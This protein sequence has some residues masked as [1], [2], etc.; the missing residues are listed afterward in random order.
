MLVLNRES[1]VLCLCDKRSMV[2]NRDLNVRTSVT[3]LICL[4]KYTCNCVFWF[5]P[6]IMMP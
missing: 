5:C 1:V 3:Y 4:S 2:K 6:L